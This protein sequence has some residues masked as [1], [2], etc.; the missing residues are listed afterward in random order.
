[1]TALRLHVATVVPLTRTRLAALAVCGILALGFGR[2]ATAQE[3]GEDDV[4]FE[5]GFRYDPMAFVEQSDSL[6]AALVR[7]HVFHKPRPGDD[8]IL[9]K[10][11]EEI[12]AE[13]REDG[14]LGKPGH[15][16]AAKLMELADCGADPNRPEVKRAIEASLRG[17]EDKDGEVWIRDIRALCMFGVIDP[18]QV[19]ASLQ[20]NLDREEEWNGPYKICPWGQAFY[21]RALWP[22]REIIDTT[23]VCRRTLTWMVEG[24]ND[25]GCVSYKDPWGLVWAAGIID[26]PE[27]KRLVE[28]Q[29]RNILRGQKPDGGW[30]TDPYDQWSK[31]SLKVYQALVNHGLFDKLRELPPLPPDWRI[32]REIPAPEGELFTMTY[33]GE[34]LWVLDRE[35]SEA[36]AV[37]PGDGSVQ[38]RLKIPFEKPMGIGWWDDGLGV[39]Q[40]GPKRVVKLNPETGEIVRELAVDKPD[41][42]EVYDLAQV[43]GELWVSDGF[44][45]MVRKIDPEGEAEPKIIDTAGV[46]P[47]SL[48]ETPDGVWEI[49]AFAP[50]IIKSD[51]EGKLLEWGEK[52]FDGRCDGL[53]WDGEHLW[54]LDAKAKRICVIEKAQ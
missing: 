32:G 22:A 44:N 41:W 26:L 13:Q 7:R 43:N 30:G 14:S 52:P 19:K 49:D 37:S 47:I 38:K 9:Q 20:A 46:E 23:D 17:Q 35:A 2:G 16:K 11:V 4:T 40:N 10:R 21:L 45:G 5:Y 29:V 25:A 15:D 34:R 50:S 51:F 53:A 8:E 28:L 24:L 48:A 36:I 31:N 3:K 54:A 42:C 33:D 27:A 1:M 39:T 6:Q 18:P 12:I